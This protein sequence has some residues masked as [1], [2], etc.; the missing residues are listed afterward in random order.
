MV[1]VKVCV[2]CKGVIEEMA[3][4]TNAVVAICVVLVAG[5]AVGAN[6]TPVSVGEADNTTDVVP[7]DVVTPVPPLATLSVPAKVIAPVVAVFGVKPVDPAENE[8]TPAPDTAF[9]T[10]AVVAICVVLVA[11]AAVGATGMPVK[12]GLLSGA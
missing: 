5:A 4:V 9:V 1:F 8:E 10:N 3:E 7:V 2:C 6:G 12:V 11:G